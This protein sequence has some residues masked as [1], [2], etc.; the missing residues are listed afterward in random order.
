MLFRSG[1][2]AARAT[3]AATLDEVRRAMRINY[4]DDTELIEQQAKAYANR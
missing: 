3:A 1:S 2:A 4:F